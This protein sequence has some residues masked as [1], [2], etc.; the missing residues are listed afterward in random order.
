MATPLPVLGFREWVVG[1]SGLV[2][3]RGEK[4]PVATMEAR[5]ETGHAAPA[6][7]CACGIYAIEEWPRL[8]D[9]RLYEEAAAPFR[10]FA[11]VLLAV[12]ALAGVAL[13]VLMVRPFIIHGSWTSAAL[14]GVP[15]GI[16]LA[17][18]G[19]AVLTVMRPT[20]VLGAVL[21]TGRVLRYRNG[22]MRAE[23][24]RVA[25][26]VR[27]IGVS[28]RIAGHLG[29]DLGVPVFQ[30]HERRRALHYLSEHGDAWARSA[31]A[32]QQED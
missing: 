12:V 4:W 21:L 30:W 15:M 5:C 19:A 22:V 32:A 3:I 16:G 14:V 27:P 23:H 20:H 13:L 6:D 28:R 8:G 18:V 2:G 7:G 26:L 25:C 31:A 17:G 10:I 29:A 9:R 1:Q 11:Q 24:A